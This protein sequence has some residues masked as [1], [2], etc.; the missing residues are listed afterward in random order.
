M[1][2]R[3]LRV[4]SLLSL[5]LLGAASASAQYG[6]GGYG[7][8][9]QLAVDA[10]AYGMFSA[11]HYSGQGV[12]LGTAP[13][14]SGGITPLGGTFG[15]FAVGR[16]PGP[17]RVGGDVRFVIENSANSTPYGDK[18]TAGFVGFRVDGSGLQNTYVIPYFQF[19]VGGAGT[20]NG[21]SLTKQGSFAYQ[22]QF[23]A[24]FPLIVHGLSSRVEYGAGQL[25]QINNTSHTLQTFS[26]GLVFHF[27]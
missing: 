13:N 23:G 3:L 10:A 19:E 9:P 6:R 7:R 14:Q 15:F 17:V 1:T 2:S 4:T 26:A 5:A 21:T 24:D 16:T 8:A 27:Q 25:T 11:A 20:N 12:G 18:L 22:A